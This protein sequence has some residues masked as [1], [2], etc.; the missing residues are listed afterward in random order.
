MTDGLPLDRPV[1]RQ[2]SALPVLSDV[3][4]MFPTKQNLRT[5]R[6]FP[7]GTVVLGVVAGEKAR[8]Y[9]LMA[10]AAVEQT[11]LKDTLGDIAL[12]LTVESDRIAA[13][14]ADGDDEIACELMTLAAWRE[15][16]PATDVND[17]I[18]K[19]TQEMIARM[20]KEAR[21]RAAARNAQT[22]QP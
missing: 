10:L 7:P 18:R 1:Q 4:P 11:T 8:A 14:I 12:T 6:E 5:Y 2:D 9:P 20:Q 16:H 15:M 19:L 21:E 3:R 13:A 17:E 22:T